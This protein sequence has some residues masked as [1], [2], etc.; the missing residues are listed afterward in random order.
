MEER[1]IEKNVEFKFTS[2]LGIDSRW[3][4][5]SEEEVPNFDLKSS[6]DKFDSFVVHLI[7]TVQDRGGLTTVAKELNKKRKKEFLTLD[8]Q[9]TD[10]LMEELWHKE[11][12]PWAELFMDYRNH[13]QN[14]SRGLLSSY[15]DFKANNISYEYGEQ[16]QGS[17][18]DLMTVFVSSSALY[19]LENYASYRKSAKLFFNDLKVLFSSFSN[20]SV[21]FFMKI[22][23][24]EKIDGPTKE[25]V[26][27][28]LSH[29]GMKD[30]EEEE[31][32]NLNIDID[33]DMGM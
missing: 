11:N 20:V 3:A 22:L 26:E 4:F 16:K 8:V 30:P 29:Y 12:I 24:Q 14:I 28:V 15:F 9:Y 19:V 10:V 5:D 32:D 1:A 13:F 21:K 25:R 27:E 31:E 7:N 18:I 6:E 2:F 33:T 23:E 17:Y